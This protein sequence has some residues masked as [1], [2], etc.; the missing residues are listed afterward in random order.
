VNVG[1]PDHRRSFVRV[2]LGAIA[3]NVAV[4]RRTL[5]RDCAFGAVVKADGYGH[6][7][8]PAA[9]AALAGGASWLLV[10]TVPEGIE[11]RRA[12][13]TDVPILVLGAVAPEEAADLIEYDLIPTIDEGS[14]IE[15]IAEAAARGGAPRAVHIKVDT[16]LNRFGVTPDHVLRFARRIVGLP[17]LRLDGLATHF[18]T[19]DVLDDPFLR[20][21]ADRFAAV[22]AALDAAGMRPRTIHAANSGAA[23]QGV[24]RWGMVRV[25]IAMYGIPPAPDFPMPRGICPALSV[26]SR[27]ARVLDLGSGATVGYGRTFRATGPMR[28]ALVPLG[29]ADGMPRSASNRGAVLIRG[30]RCPIIGLV[31]MDQCV[32]GLPDN[33]SVRIDDPV[34]VV[35]VEGRATQTLTDLAGDAGTISYELAVHFGARMR[36]EYVPDAAIQ[37]K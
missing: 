6:G 2:D 28:A 27:V 22:I 4:I 36:R 23:L 16:G 15:E 19:A 12:G 13:M 20:E 8:V 24:G 31:S 26:H 17:M 11:L 18:A 37:T 35:G 1:I 14:P 32:V 7:A 34:T 21:Q 33:V 10:A 3:R 9:R 25:G 5:P 30:E 29:Y